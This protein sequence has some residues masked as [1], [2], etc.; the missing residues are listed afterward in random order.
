MS[1]N[2]QQSQQRSFQ[3]FHTVGL[4]IDPIHIGTG[5]ARLGRVDNTIVRDP[6]T[7]I[8]KIPGSSLA[9][10]HRAYAAMALEDAR[11]ENDRRTYYPDDAGQGSANNDGGGP[12][13][14]V[15]GHRNFAG[16]AAFSDAQV[17]LFPVASREGP[18]WVT[19]PSAL[20]FVGANATV[21]DANKN[22]AQRGGEK[23]PINLG[24]LQ[25]EA[26]SWTGLQA[27]KDALKG[28]GVCEDL[29]KDLRVTERLVLVSDKLFGHVVNSNLEVR[30]SVA[31]NPAT[32]AAE[33]GALFTYEAIP[34]GSIL[35]WDVT[36]RDPRHFKGKR[37]EDAV[38]NTRQVHDVVA[39]AHP[40][41]AALGIGGMGTRGM[42]RLE[43]LAV[44]GAQ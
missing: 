17:V 27:V 7:R 31:I 2:Q 19:S 23:G 29:Y 44:G 5:G 33:D 32:G 34:R 26:E 6:V 4:A 9:G 15:F 8:P 30:T 42:G 22:K 37:S 38:T 20:H 14:A 16:L 39:K 24:W 3:V 35:M 18:L 28:F 40:L 41:L 25:L 10:V 21:D 13:N 36:C 11:T 12:I 43:V 1:S